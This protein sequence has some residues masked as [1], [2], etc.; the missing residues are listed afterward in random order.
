MFS[1]SEKGCTI[2]G[3]NLLPAGANS[4]L[5][6]LIPFKKSLGL[7]DNKQ[8]SQKLSPLYIMVENLRSVF[9]DLEYK[10]QTVCIFRIVYVLCR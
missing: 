2:K 8:E 4:F 7:Q 10:V 9:S 3:K 1:L 6:E 5:L